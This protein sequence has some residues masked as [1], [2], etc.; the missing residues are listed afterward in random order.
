M[1][2]LSQASLEGLE[3]DDETS[4]SSMVLG[5][6]TA[7]QVIVCDALQLANC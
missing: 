1:V 2:E 7:E 6:S 3:D 5:G 4:S